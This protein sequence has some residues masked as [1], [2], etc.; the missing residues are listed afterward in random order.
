MI[1]SGLCVPLDDLEP[2]SKITQPCGPDP[3]VY[4]R[5]LRMFSQFLP[6]RDICLDFRVA[7]R[8]SCSIRGLR[9]VCVCVCI[10]LVVVGNLLASGLK[11]TQTQ[12]LTDRAGL[13]EKDI[14]HRRGGLTVVC[15][16]GW[17]NVVFIFLLS[18]FGPWFC[19][20]AM[21]LPP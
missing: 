21:C 2:V 11:A 4:F 13:T 8:K 6:S 5:E 1:C 14:H 18:S 12:R 9:E 20:S 16:L 19:I 3:R 15:G 17:A 7:V 10:G